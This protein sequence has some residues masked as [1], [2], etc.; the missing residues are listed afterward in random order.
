MMCDQ[1]CRYE[2]C[3]DPETAGDCRLRIWPIPRDARC[4]DP[5]DDIETFE[6]EEENHVPI[7]TSDHD[8]PGTQKY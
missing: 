7:T 4:F 6:E 5:D 1:N 2:L 3:G 8:R